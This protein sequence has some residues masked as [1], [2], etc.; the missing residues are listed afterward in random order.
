ML[1]FA[2]FFTRIFYDGGLAWEGK[3]E[4]SGDR[5]INND[6]QGAACVLWDMVRV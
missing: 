3:V 1:R 4:E 5:E 6:G 2:E